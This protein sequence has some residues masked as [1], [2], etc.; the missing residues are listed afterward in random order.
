MTRA[1]LLLRAAPTHSDGFFCASQVLTKTTLEVEAVRRS[2]LP[3]HMYMFSWIALWSLCFG[4]AQA[5]RKLNANCNNCATLQDMPPFS[6]GG[7]SE[8]H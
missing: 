6:R 2:P 4:V 5:I 1:G 3:V 8:A 7:M